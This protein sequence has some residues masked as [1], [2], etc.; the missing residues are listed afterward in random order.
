[1]SRYL[2]KVD[3]MPK[4]GISDPQ[5]QTIERAL[6]A[7]GLVGISSVRV[8]K[9]ISLQIDA[10]DEDDARRR[11]DEVCARLLSNPVIESFDVVV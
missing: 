9:S 10:S 4:D 8:G 6:P 5:G 1:M 2:A 11:V 7:L 3:V